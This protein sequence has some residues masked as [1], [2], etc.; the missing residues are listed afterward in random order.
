M[1]KLFIVTIL[2]D[3]QCMFLLGLDAFGIA[4]DTLW[5]SNTQLRCHI[6]NDPNGDIDRINQK[7]PKKSKGANLERK[8]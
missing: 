5:I 2:S 1:R 3:F 6:G 8:S 4:N 7:D